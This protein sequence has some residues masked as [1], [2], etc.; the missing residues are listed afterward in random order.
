V[1]VNIVFILKLLYSEFPIFKRA[2]DTCRWKLLQVANLKYT[3]HTIL[4]TRSSMT[5][6][7]NLLC[8]V[9]TMIQTVLAT[10]GIQR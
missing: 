4:K 6:I 9:G 8:L 5:D 1:N 7:F 3:I 10:A 2:Q